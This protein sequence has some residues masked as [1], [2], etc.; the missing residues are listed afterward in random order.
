MNRKSSD[1]EKRSPVSML[2]VGHEVALDE[3]PGGVADDHGLGRGDRLQARGDVRSLAHDRHPLPRLAHAHLAGDHHPGVNAD[4]DTE[5]E[6]VLG[7][8][9]GVELLQFLEH[10]QAGVHGALGAVLARVGVAKVDDDPVAGVAGR[11]AVEAIGGARAHLLITAEDLAEVLRVERLGQRRGADDVAEHHRHVAAVGLTGRAG[12]VPR[13]RRRVLQRA[14]APAAEPHS[15]GVLQAAV[16]ADHPAR[17]PH[18][19][20]ALT[21]HRL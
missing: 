17:G 18:K 19:Q 16:P 20:L 5:R 6:P 2:C 12:I 1:S 4:A 21:C 15:V 7:A 3:I 11:V 8:Q 14:A 13:G 10:R 9:L